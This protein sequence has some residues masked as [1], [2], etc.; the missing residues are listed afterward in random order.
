MSSAI[1]LDLLLWGL[2]DRVEGKH[3]YKTDALLIV[4]LTTWLSLFVV[5]SFGLHSLGGTLTEVA[6]LFLIPLLPS[7]W[8]GT[9]LG[10][11]LA[12]A[13]IGRRNTTRGRLRKEVM[14][15]RKPAEADV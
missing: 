12:L 15:D 5:P 7:S 2:G 3:D 13:L 1:W 11:G 6:T 8:I 9:Q 14:T 10:I 4:N